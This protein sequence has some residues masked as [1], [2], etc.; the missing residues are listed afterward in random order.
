[1]HA[2][3]QLIDDLSLSLSLCVCLTSAG[4]AMHGVSTHKP[5]G[6]CY[7]MWIWASHV[8]AESLRNGEAFAELVGRIRGASLELQLPTTDN[9][10]KQIEDLELWLMPSLPHSSISW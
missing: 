3:S 6:C 1:M 2:S 7:H 10:D 9:R 5:V 8:H 4:N